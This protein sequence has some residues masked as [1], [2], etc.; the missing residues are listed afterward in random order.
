MTRGGGL[1]ISSDDEEAEMASPL[2]EEEQKAREGEPRSLRYEVDE[3]L[4]AEDGDPNERV[5]MP[6]SWEDQCN[7]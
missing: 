1:Q 3:N 2:R 7:E 6:D 4:E 5:V